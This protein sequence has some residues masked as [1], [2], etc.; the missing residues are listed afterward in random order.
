[1]GLFD[2][3]FGK[4]VEEQIEENASAD[5]FKFD[6]T[7][8]EEIPDAETVLESESEIVSEPISE[9]W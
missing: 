6:L 8:S 2:K 5:I 3:I 7:E 9:I 1:M 4:K